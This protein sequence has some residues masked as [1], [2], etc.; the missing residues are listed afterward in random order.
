MAMIGAW[1][2]QAYRRGFL[3]ARGRSLGGPPGLV[4]PR[5]PIGAAVLIR[6]A[7][8][9][10]LLVQQTYRSSSVWLPPGGWVDRGETPQQAARREAWEEVGLRITV[11]RALA[12]G[13]GGYG[14]VTVLFE[15]QVLGEPVLQL[16]DEIERADFFSLDALP[17]MAEQTWRWLAEALETLGIEPPAFVPEDGKERSA[18]RRQTPTG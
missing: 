8:G 12:I 5:F 14:E 10:I 7:H 17:P 18:A 16:S 6:D 13:G 15:G 1:L 9:R 2:R 4:T 11:G 3:G